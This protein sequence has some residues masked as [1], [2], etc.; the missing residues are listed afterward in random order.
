MEKKMKKKQKNESASQKRRRLSP[1]ARRIELLEAAIKMLNKLGPTHARVE[2]ITRA[3]GAAK[4]T[5][6]LY[7][8]SWE[9]MLAAVREHILTKYVA[10]I[11]KRFTCPTSLDWWPAFSNECVEFIHFHEDLGKL[12]EAIFHGVIA[13]R[14]IDPALSTG[15]ILGWMLKKGIE[16]GACRNL[17]VDVAAQLVFSVMHTMADNIIRTKE[18]EP[19]LNTTLDLLRSWL[20]VPRPKTR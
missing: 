11:R 16:I 14:P 8:P 13:E 1:E 18:R 3:A 17:D 19:Y 20:C 4:G 5:F 9:D 12:H 7:F 6:Y 10:E 2:D 15:T